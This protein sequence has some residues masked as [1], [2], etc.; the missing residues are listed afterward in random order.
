MRLY[1]LFILLMC[2]ALNAQISPMLQQKMAVAETLPVLIQ[3]KS[4]AS[5]PE[6]KQNWTKIQKAEYISRQLFDH[7]LQS[8]SELR[9]YLSDRSI[10]H[11][12]Y[13]LVNAIWAELTVEEITKLASRSEI[14]Q[15]SYDSPQA[16]DL[17]ALDYSPRLKSRGPEITW[18]I[19]RIGAE[20]V[21]QLGYKGQGVVVGGN[22]TGVKWDIAALK[23]QYRGYTPGDIDHN[24]SWHDAIHSISPLNTSGDNPCGL[25]TKEPCDDHS[26]GTHTV[27]TMIGLTDEHAI[28]V[29]PEAK[30]IACRN[31]ERGSGAPSTYIE[32]FEFFL[33]PTDLE[34]K[35][36]KPGMAPHVINNSWFCSEEEGCDTTIFPI[37]EIAVDNLKKSGVFVAVSAGNS[38]AACGTLKNVPAIYESSFTVGATSSDDKISNFSCNGPVTNYKDI[39]IKPNVVAPGSDVLSI[40]PD[41]SFASWSGT[42]MAGPHVAGLV[43][44][45]IS[46]NPALSGQV[47]QLEDIIEETATHLVADFDCWPSNGSDLPNNT[48]GYGLIN[49][50]LAVRKAIL[51][52]DN[53]NVEA[54]EL[55]I[56]PNPASG[57]I[58][59]EQNEF[60]EG[61]WAIRDVFGGVLLKGENREKNFSIDLNGLTPGIYFLCSKNTI[62]QLFSIVE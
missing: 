60:S 62:R 11:R 20:K 21:W 23:K 35:N 7:A 52:I 47:E 19:Q 51:Y 17:P 29:A 28:G 14:K 4:E 61:A 37:M 49:A 44:L 56:Y 33:A 39:R 13:Y 31:M 24:Y 36:K 15:I 41:E 10:N 57:K 45:L 58:N 40:L 48:F 59:I 53:T 34:G 26:H 50:E 9:K 3:L 25:D 43:A 12:S 8:Q 16:A 30:W 27:G 54:T 22:D 18:G 5:F 2:S 1:T 32:C 55:K 46:A 42:S 38:G 6:W